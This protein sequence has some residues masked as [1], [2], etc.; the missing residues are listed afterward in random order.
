MVN[1]FESIEARLSNIESL[2]LDIK[3]PQEKGD[4]SQSEELLTVEQAA[5][6]LDLS[7]TYVY[8][9]ISRGELPVMK[10][11]ARVYFSKKELFDYVKAGRKKTNA[12]LSAEADQYSR[13]KKALRKV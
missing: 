5:K 12:E 6:Y 11:G 7:K 1:P 2:L 4:T 9:L 13:N 10:R 8:R 3:H